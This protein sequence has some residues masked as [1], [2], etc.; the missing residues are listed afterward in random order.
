MRL[1]NTTSLELRMFIGDPTNPRFPRYAILSHTWEEE[2]VTFQDIQDLDEAKKK[3]GFSKIAKC[4][5]TALEEGLGWAWVDTCCINKHDEVELTEVSMF[6]WYEAATICY[7]YLSDVGDARIAKH[8]EWRDSRWFT[9]GWTLQELVAPFEV[10][11]YDCTWKQLGTKRCLTK[12]LGEKTGIPEEVL[13]YPVTRRKFSVAVRMAWAKGR[14]TTKIED[15]AYSLLGFFDIVSMPLMYGEGKKSFS[16]LHQN[17]IDTQRDE[18]IFLGGLISLDHELSKQSST[19]TP[20]MVGQGF[21]VTP[22]NVPTQPLLEKLHISTDI[23]KISK[24]KDPRLRGDVLSMPMRIIQVTFSNRAAPIPITMKRQTQIELDP[25]SKRALEGFDMYGVRAMGGSLCLGMLRCG[26]KDGRVL[27]RYFL[28]FSANDELWAYP[29]GIY[30]YVTPAEVYHWPNIQCHIF[31][32]EH[33]WKPYPSLELLRDVAGW[34]SEPHLS[35][36]F[37]NGW[38][39]EART[40]DNTETFGNDADTGIIKRNTHYYNL[41]FRP[42][43]QVWVVTVGL[44]ATHISRQQGNGHVEVEIN[45]QCPTAPELGTQS[46]K[47]Q[48]NGYE[49]PVTELFHRL[50]VAGGSAELVVSV[51][52]GV[53]EGIH[54]YSP[55]V[56]FRAFEASENE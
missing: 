9:R 2:E 38:S 11:I 55:M 25:L 46:V 5:E 23:D 6:K 53:N 17:I 21:L 40:T 8:R 12:E 33:A 34:G 4:C 44:G 13:L 16:R 35:G 27:A 36:T 24:W 32:D 15:R 48:H 39:W 45:L 30:R 42:K 26:T 1:I 20:T 54:Y 14:Q 7:A 28:C 18:T 37:S 22:D 56:R 51:Y 52:Y 3:V 47:L 10:I 43:G 41:C 50:P 49:G 19:A 29:M 31:L